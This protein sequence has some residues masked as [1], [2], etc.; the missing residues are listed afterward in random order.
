MGGNV[1]FDLLSN[2]RTELSCDV[3]VTVGSQ[4]G[5]FAELGLL[6]AVADPQTAGDRQPRPANIGRWINVFDACD[7]LSFATAGIFDGTE[8]FVY[9][10]GSGAV[11][12]H[13]AYFLRP[14]FFR[15]LARHLGGAR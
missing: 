8:D 3:L 12:S 4:V 14:S 6:P 15:R 9:S 11:R 7:V 5:L 1:V 10:T 13:S 2:L